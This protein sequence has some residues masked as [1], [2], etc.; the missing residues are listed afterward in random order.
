MRSVQ[1]FTASRHPIP[2]AFRPT[3]LQMRPKRS[4]ARHPTKMF[5]GAAI[6]KKLDAGLRVQR[7]WQ[8][9]VEEYGY[10][11]SSNR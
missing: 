2:S 10:G 9:V 7:I 8:D 11:A 3:R 1:F 4:P 5:P 6:T